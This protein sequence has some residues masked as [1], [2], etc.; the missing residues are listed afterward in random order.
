[1]VTRRRLV[2]ALGAGACLNALGSNA[3]SV[4]RPQRV[5]IV[6]NGSSESDQAFREAFSQSLSEQGF[7]QPRNLKIDAVYAEG[8]SDRLSQLLREIISR[9]PDVIVVNGSAA[10]RAAKD[11]TSTIPIV[12]AAV[13]DPVAL[14]LVNS[15]ARPGG[16]IT[17]NAIMA[18][19]FVPKALEILH[20]AVPSVRTFGALVDTNMPVA[21]LLLKPLEDT[22]KRL[23]VSLERY[24]AR[25]PEEL[26]RVLGAFSATRPAALMVLPFPLFVTYPQKIVDSLSRNRIP[27]ILMIDR[28]AEIGG[29]MAYGVDRIDLWRKAAFY[30]QRI[31]RGARPAELAVEQPTKF[32]LVVNLKAANAMSIKI[33]QSIL[34]RA[35]RIIR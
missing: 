11:A 24:E 15:L 32:E 35:D 7:Q 26:E 27:A 1:M 10:S 9:Q 19:A 21:P 22:S 23:G 13:G 4:E 28:G 34:V 31:L 18:E 6:F 16:N 20:E 3:Q 30:V 12:M 5:G 25:S 33:P 29:L 8:K 2:L 14:G 17:G